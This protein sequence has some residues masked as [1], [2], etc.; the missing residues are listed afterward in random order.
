MKQSKKFAVTGGIGS[1][2]SALINILKELGY[3]VFSCDEIYAELRREEGYLEKLSKEF[4]ECVKDGHFDFTL[5]SRLVFSSKEA[6][7]RLNALSHPLIM[8]RLL[9]SMEGHE[10]AFAEVPLLFEGGYETLFDDVIAV[11]R[12]EDERIAAVCRRDRLSKEEVRSRIA[13]Q[14]DERTYRA[15]GAYIVVNDGSLIH[16]KKKAE[17]LLK[18]LGL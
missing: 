15:K 1:G 16:L 14:T 18:A 9:K 7:D 3:P 13:A 12:R 2:K 10:V 4:D 11:V 5:L 17:D 8:E 6:R